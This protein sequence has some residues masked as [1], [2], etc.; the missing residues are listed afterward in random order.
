[1]PAPPAAKLFNDPIHG[2]I[3][4][5]RGLALQL[6]DHPYLQR[7]RRIQ[8]LGLGSLVFPGATH[9]RFSH[10]LGAY[11]LVSQALRS[12]REKGVYISEAEY[13]ATQ[14]A[15]LL[16]DIGHA[17][18]SHALEHLLV[19]GLHH[20]TMS[21]ALMKQLNRETG[22]R[23]EL[24][25]QIFTGSYPAPYLHQLVSG[26]LDMDRLDYL[27]RDSFF[28]GV[29][30]GI[31]GTD[32]I[33]KTLNV[34]NRE[35]VVEQKGVYAVEKFLIAR[36]LMYWQVYLH[37]ASVVAEAMLIGILK[38]ARTLLLAGA[39]LPCEPNLHHLLALPETPAQLDEQLIDPYTALDDTDIWFHIKR[40][41]QQP[42]RVLSLLC[43]GILHRRLLKIR[44]QDQPFGEDEVAEQRS[45]CQARLGLDADEAAYFV[46]TARLSNQAYAPTGE[47]RR[48][49]VLR[50]D[51]SLTD[52]AEASDPGMV[53]QLS[54]PVYKY[55]LCYPAEH[56]L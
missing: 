36:R 16:H 18:F 33:L 19:P 46:H 51:G 56:T 50:K 22:G 45:L 37:K 2:F 13:E 52:I 53:A 20:E 24:A 49:Q 47:G 48:I 10:A 32:R 29:A 21:L 4:V 42:D 5:R 55:F 17:P 1:M 8:Q 39:P 43:Q 41:Q 9:A 27:T 35:L 54:R 23:L 25:M 38:R 40:W 34:A 26:Q 14:L 44:V 6:A 28:T 31:V 15:I 30:E 11:H 7:L 3:E 12:L